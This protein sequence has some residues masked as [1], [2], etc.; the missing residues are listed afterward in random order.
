MLS[1]NAYVIR[2]ATPG[3]I[4]AL[5]PSA[6]AEDRPA[7]VGEIAGRPAAAL[8]AD[9]RMVSNPLLA[10]PLLRSYVRMRAEAL[11]AHVRTPSV[12]DRLR[13]GVPV[14]TVSASPA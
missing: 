9:G 5:G 12:S 2:F 4:R 7:L 11:R 6:G 13:A 8:L 1:S 3:E 10:T 14:A